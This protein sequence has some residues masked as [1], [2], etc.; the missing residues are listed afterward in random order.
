MERLIIPSSLYEM[1]P[2]GGTCEGFMINWM[3]K[4][5]GWLAGRDDY[6]FHFTPGKSSGLLTHGGSMANLTALAAARAAIAPDSWT[7]GNPSDL[8]VIGAASAHYSIARAL[9]IL[10][11]GKKLFTPWPLTK[12]KSY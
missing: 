4:K 11:L 2:A 3:L 6:D 9:S 8:V 12:T 10:G 1:G 5:M 7:E